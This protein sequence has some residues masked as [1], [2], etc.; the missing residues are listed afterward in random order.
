MHHTDTKV[1]KEEY[2]FEAEKNKVSF[3]PNTI[4]YTAH[5]KESD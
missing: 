2:L 5:G 3:T 1:L 4:T